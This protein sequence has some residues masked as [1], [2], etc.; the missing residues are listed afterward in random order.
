[1]AVLL[2]DDQK[3]HAVKKYKRHAA[4]KLGLRFHLAIA[5]PCTMERGLETPKSESLAF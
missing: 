2:F 5:I 3:P 4:I 1:M